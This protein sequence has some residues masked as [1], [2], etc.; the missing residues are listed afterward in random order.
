MPPEPEKDRP[1]LDYFNHDNADDPTVAPLSNRSC[2]AAVFL[3]GFSAAIGIAGGLSKLSPGTRTILVITVAAS[4]IIA[5]FYAV[6][7]IRAKGVH[8]V[9]HTIGILSLFMAGL[10]ILG[11][12]LLLI[13]A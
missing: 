8:Y 5:M 12:F 11:A 6:R 13:R 10:C 1:T 2:V 7:G 3:A 4:A 9:D